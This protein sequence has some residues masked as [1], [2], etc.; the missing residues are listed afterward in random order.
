MKRIARTLTLADALQKGRPFWAHPWSGIL[1]LCVLFGNACKTRRNEMK[2]INHR[3]RP[4]I[5]RPLITETNPGMTWFTCFLL[6]PNFTSSFATSTIWI[7]QT[8]GV[9][10]INRLTQ[11][12]HAI[13][14]SVPRVPI[15][16]RTLYLSDRYICE[17]RMIF[18]SQHR[19]L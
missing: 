6:L 8:G 13:N 16:N 18:S 9:L 7:H 15:Q 4:H 12:G 17:G 1:Y 5:G 3:H 11:T 10:T 19:S 2:G 14:A